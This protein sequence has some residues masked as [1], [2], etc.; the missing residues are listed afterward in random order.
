[1]TLAEAWAP[2]KFMPPFFTRFKAVPDKDIEIVRI[3][4]TEHEYL[5]FDSDSKISCHFLEVIVVKSC[6]I[7]PFNRSKKE[8]SDA[9]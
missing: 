1:M 9:S 6:F 5:M 8:T 7:S 3:E 2:L 4:K